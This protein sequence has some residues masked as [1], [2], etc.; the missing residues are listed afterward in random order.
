M[1]RL[2]YTRIGLTRHTKDIFLFSH[3]N[4]IEMSYA[5]FFFQEV[6]RHQVFTKSSYYDDWSKHVP[7]AYTTR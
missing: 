7:I 1:T 6:N 5:Y 4:K 2:R 3:R